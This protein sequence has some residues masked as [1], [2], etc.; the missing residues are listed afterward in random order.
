MEYKL[1]AL[2]C[3]SFE[4]KQDGHAMARMGALL[5]VAVNASDLTNVMRY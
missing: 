3:D 4:T 5:T 2:V 1:H